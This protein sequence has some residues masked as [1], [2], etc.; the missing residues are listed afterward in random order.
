MPAKW[1]KSRKKSIFFVFMS[2]YHSV[3]IVKSAKTTKDANELIQRSRSC[4]HSSTQVQNTKRKRMV[5]N[6]NSRRLSLLSFASCLW[7]LC[8]H[9]VYKYLQEVPIFMN[10]KKC[11]LSIDEFALFWKGQI[12]RLIWLNLIVFKACNNLGHN[13]LPRL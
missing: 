9:Y 7:R 10:A 5:I 4:C 12:N 3:K 2:F 6:L 1:L 11:S 13:H 8:D